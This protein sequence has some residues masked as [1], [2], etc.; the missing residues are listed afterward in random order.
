MGAV[1]LLRLAR[2]F[3]L[4]RL[5]V[6]GSSLEYRPSDVPLTEEAPVEPTTA[7]GAAKAA[8]TLIYRQAAL[9]TGLPVYV[10]RFF[11]VWSV[12]IASPPAAVRDPC[13]AR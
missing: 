5:V 10:L 4:Q 13:R 11:H 1:H 6:A 2:E 8:A 12:G 9:E 3:D 7:H